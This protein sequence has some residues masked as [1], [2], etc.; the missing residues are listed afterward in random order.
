MMQD[1]SVLC[2]RTCLAGAA[3]ASLLISFSDSI[4]GILLGRF[5]AGVPVFALPSSSSVKQV[6]TFKLIYSYLFMLLSGG[7]LGWH[8]VT[9]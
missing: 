8:R 7:C 9:E 1:Q 5:L 4:A 2:S 6:L 3:F